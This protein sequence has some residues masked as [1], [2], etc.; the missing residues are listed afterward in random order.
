V[1]QQSP[2]ALSYLFEDVP[3]P[4]EVR[5]IVPGVRWLRMPLPMAL[6]HINLYLLEDTDGWWVIDTGIAVDP[7]EALWEQVFA[8]ELQG[9][10]IKAV[11]AT[12]YHPDHIGMAGWICERW[13]VPFYMTEVEYLSGLSFSRMQREHYSWSSGQYLQH[14]G[15]NPEQVEHASTRFGGFGDYIKPMP[16]AYRRMVDGSSMVIN[17]HRWRVVVGRGHS[18]EHACLYCESLNLL[19]SGDQVIPKITSN[20]SVMAGE[21][22]ANPL[23]EWLASHERLLELLPADALVLPAHNAPFYGLHVRLRHL[24]EHHEEHLL[25]LEEACVDAMPTALELLPVLFKRPLD[26]N[27]IGLALGEWIAHLNFLHHR[28]QLER[29]LNEA[30]HYV[31]RSIDDTLGLRLRRHRP[32]ADDQPPIQV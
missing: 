3:E 24:I 14:A 23:K 1:S 9:K 2:T 7:T 15:F 17:G 25:A 4:G 26:D 12:H 16:T 20:V 13:R 29:V 27:H 22:E 21:P 8:S 10:P 32:V 19:I 11:L 18:P 28:G 6:D 5:D 31:Y 30:G